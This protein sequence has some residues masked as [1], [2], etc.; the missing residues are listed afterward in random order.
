MT[1]AAAT[2][3]FHELLHTAAERALAKYPQHT[4][5]IQRGLALALAGGVT[6][7]RD[8][9]AL[10]DSQGTPGTQYHVTKQCECPD[11]QRAP[12]GLCKHRWAKALTAKAHKAKMDAQ[13]PQP[14][15]CFF[16]HLHEAPGVLFQHADG[17]ILFLNEATD[18]ITVITPALVNALVVL[19]ETTLANDQKRYDLHRGG[20][21]GVACTRPQGVK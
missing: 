2:V 6:L 10:V 15:R 21:V 4:A 12:D 13:T 7:H 8:G 5:R 17:R 19:G 14:R 16:A 11:V 3:Q 9:T 1:A 18:Q 20:A